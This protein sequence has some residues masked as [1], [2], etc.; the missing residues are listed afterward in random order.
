[1]SHTDDFHCFRSDPL[2][3]W[4]NI[5]DALES[6]PSAWEWALANIDRWLARGRVH[7]TPLMEWR[8]SLLEGCQDQAKRESLLATLREAPADAHQE[9][10]R[11]CSPFIGGPFQ[12]P[13]L[14]A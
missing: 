11:A 3:H 2:I 8:Q 5:A 9:Q 14:S 4:R 12:K 6:D 10:L 7:P 13:A 1:M